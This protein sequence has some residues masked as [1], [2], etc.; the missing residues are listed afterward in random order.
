MLQY[1]RSRFM[2]TSESFAHQLKTY[3]RRNGLTQ[4]GLAEQ[5][6]YSHEAIS[7]WEREK[8]TPNGQEIPRLARLLGMKP[9]ELV[10]CIDYTRPRV[11]T[12]RNHPPVSEEA[13][14][15]D[16]PEE[17]LHIY[18]N[19]TDFSSNFSYPRMFEH[20]RDIL[21]VGISLNGIALTYSSEKIINLVLK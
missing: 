13:D 10:E 6:N 20:A 5:W 14:P 2:P 4:K 7:S 9:E 18:G 1:A 15:T 19:R 8:R 17:L 11:E 12:Q 21:A 16:A 3:R